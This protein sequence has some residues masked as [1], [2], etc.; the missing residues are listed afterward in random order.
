[1]AELTRDSAFDFA[2]AGCGHQFHKTLGWLQ[3]NDNIVCPGD[4][5]H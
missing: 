2:C 3:L 4:D 1:M 5:S